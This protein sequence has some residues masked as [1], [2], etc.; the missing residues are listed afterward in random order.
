LLRRKYNRY[1]SQ[2]EAKGNTGKQNRFLLFPF[3]SFYFPES[4]L[5][6]ELPAIEIKKFLHRLTRAAG[7]KRGAVQNSRHGGPKRG[8][9][10]VMEIFM[11][12]ISDFV[13]T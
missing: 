5:F 13:N 6:N 11:D 7:C 9:I 12:H 3:I 2:M 4:G 8:S 10:L 1:A